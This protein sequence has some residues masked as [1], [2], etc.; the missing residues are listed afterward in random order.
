[1]LL[2]RQL[3]RGMAD[4]ASA[5]KPPG[6]TSQSEPCRNSW[7]ESRRLAKQTC[8]IHHSNFGAGDT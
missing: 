8:L 1:M 2:A 7:R 4:M 3:I 6:V 5:T